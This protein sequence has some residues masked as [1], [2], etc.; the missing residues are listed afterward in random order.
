M[1]KVHNMTFINV[2]SLTWVE[3]LC[4]YWLEAYPSCDDRH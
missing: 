3:E 2:V 1:Q 4:D